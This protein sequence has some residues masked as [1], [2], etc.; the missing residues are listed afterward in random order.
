M[1][2]V[3]LALGLVAGG[4]AGY[5]A[6][7]PFLARPP[8]TTAMLFPADRAAVPAPRRLD[9]LIEAARAAALRVRPAAGGYDVLSQPPALRDHV[10]QVRVPN[11][12]RISLDAIAI[13]DSGSYDLIFSV[14][15]ALVPLYGPIELAESEGTFVIDGTK[16]QHELREAKAARVSAKVRALVTRLRQGGNR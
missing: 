2:V 3:W 7:P 12:D 11:P 9:E 13:G 8:A 15:L 4:V 16:D 5:V 6:L 1:T 14:V 10:V